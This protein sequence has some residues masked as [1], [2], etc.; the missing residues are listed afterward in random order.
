MKD[1]KDMKKALLNDADHL[2]AHLSIGLKTSI[3]ELR[4]PFPPLLVTAIEE[5]WPR[6]PS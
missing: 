3:T 5:E 2:M 4:N 1:N 6:Q